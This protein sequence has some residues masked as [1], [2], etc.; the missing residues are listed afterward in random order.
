MGGKFGVKLGGMRIE[1]NTFI[2]TATADYAIG[3]WNGNPESVDIRYRN[4][5]FYISNS[6]HVSNFSDF[7]HQYNLYYLGKGK[8][9]GLMHEKGEKYG[10]PLFISLQEEDF[11]V[12]QDSPALNTGIDLGSNQDFEGSRV[13]Q[14]KVPEMGA[15]ESG[16][17]SRTPE[18]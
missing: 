6:R 2:D 14:G 5:I 13:P 4:K 16:T 11:H 15:F 3:F 9:P 17:E 12:L 8:D 1:N 10:G 7:I 18:P